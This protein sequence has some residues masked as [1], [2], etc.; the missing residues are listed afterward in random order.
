MLAVL[1]QVCTRKVYES[2]FVPVFVIT[3]G[4]CLRSAAFRSDV[5]LLR[6]TQPDGPPTTRTT[7]GCLAACVCSWTLMCFALWAS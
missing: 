3:S 1:A 5:E 7:C 4:T 2:G 6:T